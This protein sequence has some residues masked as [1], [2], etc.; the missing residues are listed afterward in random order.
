[1]NI[2]GQPATV[3]YVGAAPGL[4]PG[5]VQLNV[6]IPSTTPVS[7]SVPVHI[8]IGGITSQDGVTLAVK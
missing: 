3:Q 5:V 1:V 6:Q 4:M 7:N 2:G 8:T